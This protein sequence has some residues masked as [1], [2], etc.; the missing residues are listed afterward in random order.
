MHSTTDYDQ[1][2]NLLTNAK[3]L[4]GHN[5]Q[6]FDIPHLERLLDI[7]V[8]AT[9]IDT[10][11]MAWYLEP[12]RGRYGL[13]DF[14]EEFGVPKPVVDDWHNLPIEEYIHRC[15]EDV[16]INWLLWKKQLAYLQRL[17][18][19]QEE[20]FRFIK[21]LEFKMDC[22]RE[23]ERSKWLLDKTLCTDAIVELE[24]DKDRRL[25][26][27]AEAMPKVP[28][29]KTVS[30]PS[31]MDKKSGGLT[32]AGERWL[33][34]LRENGLPDDH[35]EPFQVISGYTEPNPGSSQQVKDWL[36]SL[37]WKPQTFKFV[38]KADGEVK[39]IP[40]IRNDKSGELCESVKD[41]MEDHPEIAALDG[42]SVINHRLPMLR[43]FL[44]DMDEDGYVRAAVQGLTNTLRFRHAVLV[45]LP[46]PEKAYGSKI[47]GAL[48]AP[49]GYELCGSDMSS[50]EDK[51]KHHFLFKYDPEYVEKMSF[52]GYDPHLEIALLGNM[53]TQEDVDHYKWY[54]GLTDEEQAVVD[55]VKKD[56]FK[57]VKGVR[58]IAKNGNYA[59][60]Y[61]AGPPRIALTCDVQ[62]G[63]ARTI[64]EA[65]WKLNWAIKK[66]AEEQIVKYVDDQRWLFNPVSRF[67][68]TLRE[69][70]DRFSTLVQGTAVYV[71]DRWVEN[72][73]KID[74]QLTGQFHDEIVKLSKVGE[75]D[76]TTKLLQDA[77]ALTNEQLKL[78]R[79]LGISVAFG[80]RYSDIH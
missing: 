71:F 49:E 22:A 80:S 34:A 9:L 77:I 21:Y 24:L 74:P 62:L 45:N 64:H 28:K 29:Y 8:T 47:R 31:V 56:W 43:G 58:S 35:E 16:K 48:I 57:R 53:C 5:I 14:G 67:W 51:I 78:N 42:L 79:E 70:K 52:K 32:V 44:K 19:N 33:I 41:L 54:D 26:E 20:Y 65:Y 25:A 18:G 30:K 10:L 13:A 50:L 60:Q 59:C 75:R 68:Y 73:R 36:T 55:K 40:Q 7:K 72:F 38:K 61:G 12:G 69:E 37:G 1:M 27:L 2:R 6:R 66:V 46:K 39:A 17:Y 23:Q 76:K 4:I 11:A 15:E 63:V 3:V